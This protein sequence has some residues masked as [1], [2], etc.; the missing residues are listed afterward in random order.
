MS[1]SRHGEVKRAYQKVGLE[2]DKGSAT[3]EFI[4]VLILLLR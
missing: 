4:I 1:R 3:G 2:L